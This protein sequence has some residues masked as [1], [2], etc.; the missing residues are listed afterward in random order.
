MLNNKI[1]E[2]ENILKELGESAA[3]DTKSSAGDKHETARAM[4]QIEQESVG[5]QLKETEDQKNVLEKIEL[6]SS[7]LQIIKGSLVKTNRGYLFLSIPLGKINVDGESI[8][9]ISPQSPLGLK[10]M[11]LKANE[12]TEINGVHYSIEST[13]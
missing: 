10:M 12:M 2:L 13:C 11:G 1:Q 4:I 7:P 8:M 3:K 9:V 5:K 6:S